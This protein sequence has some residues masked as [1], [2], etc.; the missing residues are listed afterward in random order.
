MY[1]PNSLHGTPIS[2]AITGA[3]GRMG[4]RLVALASESSQFHVVAALVRPDSGLIDHDAGELSGSGVLGVPLTAELAAKP[5]VL[6]DFSTPSATL[7]WL[8]ICVERGIPMVIGTTSLTQEHQSA[9]DRASA[10][11]PILQ[12]SN[13]SFIVT[14]LRL[15]VADVA[16]LLDDSYDTEII[17]WHHRF[18]KDAPS[19]T[20]M[21]FAKDILRATGRTEK[22]LVF[23]RHSSNS[24]RRPGEIGIHSLRLGNEVCRHEVHFAALGEE[25]WLGQR[26]YSRDTF[27]S[28]ALKA[29]EWL[30]AQPNGR[31]DMNEVVAS[32][33]GS[34]LRKS[35]KPSSNG[36]GKDRRASRRRNTSNIASVRVAR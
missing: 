22:Q 2:I 30:R 27:A 35:H 36:K 11:I 20:A 31:Y 19:G 6:I 23:G 10:R 28:G 15:V 21:S 18:K 7:N 14:V 32:N 1:N 17:E 8:K 9:I 4:R 26:A 29:A 13:T 25:L 12:A 24:S 34:W 5:D 33:L 3:A 16:K